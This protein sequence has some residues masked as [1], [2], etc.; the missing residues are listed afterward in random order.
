MSKSLHNAKE[1]LTEISCGK[2][3]GNSEGEGGF[4]EEVKGVQ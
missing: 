3:K 4:F 2:G 1:L